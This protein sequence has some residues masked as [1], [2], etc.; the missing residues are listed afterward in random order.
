MSVKIISSRQKI[1]EARPAYLKVQQ[2]LLQD[3]EEGCWEPDSLIPT[4]KILAEQHKV[5]IGTIK[6]AILNLINEGW[7]YRIQGKGTFV[8]GT[9]LRRENLKYYRFLPGFF[10]EESEL[11]IG[12]LSLKRTRGKKE[13]NE[14]LN[15]GAKSDLYEL[16]RYLGAAE[17]PLIYVVSYLPVKL[18]PGMDE[19]PASKFEKTTLY[20]IVE[21]QYGMPTI[22]NQELMCVAKA[23]SETARVL[24]IPVGEPLLQMEMLSFTY[25]EMAYEYR[26]S[27]CRTDKKKIFREF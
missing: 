21:Q 24:D 25:K 17:K 3:I 9:T 2:K 18:F 14:A 19:F 11:K 6:K 27:Y 12:L 16:R 7:L 23:D 4:E 8:A 5:S 20:D 10:G 22:Y 1:E 15:I 26:Y 13:I